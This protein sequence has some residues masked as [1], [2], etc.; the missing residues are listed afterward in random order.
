MFDVI[1]QG[2][3]SNSVTFNSV[4]GTLVKSCSNSKFIR[5]HM[6]SPLAESFFLRSTPNNGASGLSYREVSVL[7]VM[8]CG[9]E[10]FLVEYLDAD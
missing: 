8:L 6:G 10:Q 5:F 4:G 3:I 7:Q 1:S 2:G 9:N